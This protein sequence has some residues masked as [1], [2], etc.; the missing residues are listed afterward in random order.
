MGFSLDETDLMI[1]ESCDVTNVKVKARMYI[2]QKL[3]R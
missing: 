2:R 3:S 1:M